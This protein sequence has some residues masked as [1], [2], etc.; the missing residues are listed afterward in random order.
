[1]LVVM[2]KSPHEDRISQ[3]LQT[4]NEQ[5]K[6]AVTLQTCYIGIFNVTNK[7]KRKHFHISI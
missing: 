4:Y 2:K 5:F 7:N 3:P 6:I 1:M